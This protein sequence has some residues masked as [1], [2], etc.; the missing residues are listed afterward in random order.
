MKCGCC[1]SAVKC[2]REL[3]DCVRETLEDAASTAEAPSVQENFQ[4][5]FRVNVIVSSCTLFSLEL[6]TKIKRLDY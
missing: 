3:L 1:N 6:I 5:T 2:C 4:N